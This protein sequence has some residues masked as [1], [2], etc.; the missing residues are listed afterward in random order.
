MK[1]GLDCLQKWKITKTINLNNISKGIYFLNI[2]SDTAVITKK[3]ILN[4]LNNV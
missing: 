1:A 4:N 2:Y 3:I